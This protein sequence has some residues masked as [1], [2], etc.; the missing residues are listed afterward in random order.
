M[1]PYFTP[2]T[3]RGGGG[4]IDGGRIEWFEVSIW[5]GPFHQGKKKDSSLN[6]GYH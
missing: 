4:T 5:D 3:D 1:G 2:Y 6:N